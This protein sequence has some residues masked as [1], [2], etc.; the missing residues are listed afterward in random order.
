[1]VVG[2]TQVERRTET[3]A[4]GSPRDKARRRTSPCLREQLSQSSR[5]GAMRS[6]AVR[7]AAYS[8]ILDENERLAS[9]CRRC[10]GYL[11]H[12]CLCDGQQ[13]S[14]LATMFF[15]HRACV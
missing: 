4:P 14:T 7:A 13:S 9:Q 11:R 8:R 10:H 1:M 2:W 3:S 6:T 12:F 5:C 15:D